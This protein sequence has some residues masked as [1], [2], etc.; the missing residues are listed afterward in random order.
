M[1]HYGDYL[2]LPRV[3]YPTIY[4]LK[5][6]DFVDL[7]MAKKPFN[8]V[9]DDLLSLPFVRLC[10]L[11]LAEGN[12]SKEGGIQFSLGES[13][14]ELIEEIVATL[15][16][17][18]LR[19]LVRPNRGS[20]GTAKSVRVR[21][22][23]V[24][25]ARLFLLWFGKGAKNKQIPNWVFQLNDNLKRSFIDAAWAGDGTQGKKGVTYKTASK[26]AAEQIF[27]L[28]H[29]ISE[30]ATLHAGRNYGFSTNM[31][32][33]VSLHHG[34]KKRRLWY[35]D[36][37]YLWIPIKTVSSENYAGLVHNLEVQGINSY[38]CNL[39]SAHNCEAAFPGLRTSY[40]FVVSRP[41]AIAAAIACELCCLTYYPEAPS[42]DPENDYELM[43]ANSIFAD[44]CS[45]AIIGCDDDSRHPSIIDF[46]SQL[47]TSFRNELG[48]IWREGRLRVRLSRRVP[49]IASMLIG[50][51][52]AE[53]LARNSLGTSDIAYWVLHPPGA[54][55]LDLFRDK[56]GIAEEKLKYSR[57]ALRLFGNCSSSTVGIVGKLLMQDVKEPKG[58]LVMANVGPGMVANASLMRFGSHGFSKG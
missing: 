46:T 7:S 26:T 4:S 8:A 49:E 41:G 53:L 16:G 45:C 2:L 6:S 27:L 39:V 14:T 13:E 10:G 15:K 1:V 31:Q 24:V 44:A 28:L 12:A 54:A 5:V 23:S 56:L 19:P 18:G 32:Y 36:N 3:H 40:D 51:A 20:S 55:V 57:K 38:V 47:D 35:L 21:V 11:Y 58:Y 30:P 25:L 17:A 52:V 34:K 37:K 9:P 42:A 22:A 29:T 48:Y 50:K 43:R 33:T